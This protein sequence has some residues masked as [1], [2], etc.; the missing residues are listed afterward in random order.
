[1]RI[2]ACPNCG[3]L[4]VGTGRMKDSSLNIA[5]PFEHWR[6]ICKDCGHTGMFIEFDSEEEYKVFL[7]E[8]QKQ[9]RSE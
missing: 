7:E 4:H 8:L 9:K 3:S 6:T 5:E 2:I 1:M